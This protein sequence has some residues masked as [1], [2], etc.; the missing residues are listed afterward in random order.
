M[1]RK[2]WRVTG[3]NQKVLLETPDEETA[4][5]RW[6]KADA[7]T[8]NEYITHGDGIALT[9]LLDR[10]AKGEKEIASDQPEDEEYFKLCTTIQGCVT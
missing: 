2:I 5:E 9:E 4:K 8:M 6:R 7:S 3:H 1:V 10:V